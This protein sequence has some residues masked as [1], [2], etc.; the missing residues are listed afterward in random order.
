MIGFVLALA[1]LQ[2]RI[3]T[4]GD[5]VWVEIRA[6]IPARMIVRPQA[7]EAGD[8]GQVL[9]PPIVESSGDKV[10]IRYPVAFWYPGDHVLDVPGPV[11]ISPDGHSDTLAVTKVVARIG[12]VLPAKVERSTLEPKP[13]SPLIARSGRSV[14]PIAVFEAVALLLTAAW[15]WLTRRRRRKDVVGPVPESRPP[16]A[17]W[18]GRW[19][20]LGEPQAAVIGWLSALARARDAGQ[21]E[22]GG[23][24]EAL[25]SARYAPVETEALERLEQQAMALLEREA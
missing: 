1:A 4:V 14:L 16:P 11:L 8:V 15:L 12:S 23:L 3:P 25:E 2:D 10:L 17:T 9:G 20:A 24:L 7:W 21:A 22:A 6:T 19:T 18:F 13:S 5:T